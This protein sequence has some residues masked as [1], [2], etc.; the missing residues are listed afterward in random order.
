MIVVFLTACGGGG[1]SGTSTDNTTASETSTTNA[2]KA[3][4]TGVSAANTSNSTG[5]DIADFYSMSTTSQTLKTALVV[6]ASEGSEKGTAILRGLK[7]MVAP[8]VLSSRTAKSS[9]RTVACSGGGSITV[10]PGSVS[11]LACK[12]ESLVT[13]GSFTW[14]T[15]LDGSSYAVGTTENPF[16]ETQYA[17]STSSTKVKETKINITIGGLKENLGNLS[18]KASGSIID[19][20]YSDGTQSTK[21]EISF[22]NLGISKNTDATARTTT[23]LTT[24]ILNDIHYIYSKALSIY[25]KSFSATSTFTNFATTFYLTQAAMGIS[26]TFTIS[27]TPTNCLDGT[28]T[29]TTTTPLK[30]NVSSK[31]ISAGEIA[32]NGST[33]KFNGDGSVTVTANGTTKTYTSLSEFSGVCSDVSLF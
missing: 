22:N 25:I 7:A 31:T 23:I 33:I 14:T 13:S 15:S 2:A 5:S 29:I 3:A 19:E 24:G 26:G 28:F 4:V 9:P 16:T 1:S 27:S 11:Y 21:D 30:I 18:M 6:P 20:S 12:E 32:V 17:S 10:N 8:F